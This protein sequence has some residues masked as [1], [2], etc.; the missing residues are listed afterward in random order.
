[1]AINMLKSIPNIFDQSGK[2][3]AVAELGNSFGNKAQ[4]TQVKYGSLTQ[5]S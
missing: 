3:V 5:I 4:L 1:M 2:M